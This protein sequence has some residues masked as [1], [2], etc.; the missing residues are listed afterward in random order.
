MSFYQIALCYLI[1][2]VGRND[3][4]NAH[5][6]RKILTTC[7]NLVAN[8][9]NRIIISSI[10]SRPVNHV[11][12]DPIIEEMMENISILHSSGRLDHF[13]IKVGEGFEYYNI[14]C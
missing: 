8:I 2:H 12:T 14:I 5:S 10:L 7:A 4:E 11:T 9:K 13:V 3:V 1:I 6:V